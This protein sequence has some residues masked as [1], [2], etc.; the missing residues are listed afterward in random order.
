MTLTP[1]AP[2]SASAKTGIPAPSLGTKRETEIVVIPDKFHGVALKIKAPPLGEPIPTIAPKPTPPP[3]APKLP[4]SVIAAPKHSPWPMILVLVLLVLTVGG[5]FTYLNRGLLFKSTKTPPVVQKPPLP[6]SAPVNVA[7]VTSSGASVSLSW[8]DTSG[9]ETGFRLERKEA[10]GTFLPL[11][12]LPANSTVFLDVSVQPN[13]TYVYRVVA[14]NASGE[15]EASNSA[16]VITPVATPSTVT[17][18]VAVLPPGGL[19]VDSDGLSDVEEPFFGTDI[20]NPDTDNDGF[21]DGNEV[22]HLYNPAA[23]APVRL[24]DAGLVSRFSSTVGWSMYAPTQWTTLLDASDG[25]RATVTTLTGERFLVSLQD[26]P[27]S[28]PLM[29]WYLASHPGVLSSAVRT[30]HTK[31][32]LEGLLGVERL[33]A[34]FAWGTKV[35]RFEYDLAGKP[36][37]NYRAT[38][39]MML[40]ALTLVGAPVISTTAEPL[41]GPGALV[42]LTE[43]ESTST[44]P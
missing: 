40:N 9:A 39:E 19:D 1:T 16:S 26:N 44:Q 6:P 29:D 37:V 22:F 41:P 12:N 15:S 36:F 32:G 5:V 43:E 13:A 23:K 31:G 18:T 20:H 42:P 4:V 17:P 38:F 34:Y 7:A 28:L 33:D 27:E 25:S 30:L 3:V 11:T 10:E 8:V 35:F 21:L 2:P 14:V 24:I